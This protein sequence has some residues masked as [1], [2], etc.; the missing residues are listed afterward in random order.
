[1]LDLIYLCFARLSLE[2]LLRLLKR[3]LF[4]GSLRSQAKG[5]RFLPQVRSNS[6]NSSWSYSC[7]IWIWYFDRPS[8]AKVSLYHRVNANKSLSIYGSLLVPMGLTCP[9]SDKG[10]QIE[11]LGVRE[12]ELKSS[13]KAKSNHKV[14]FIK[15]ALVSSI[16]WNGTYLSSYAYT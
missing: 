7:S 12:K 5:I 3:N 13:C 6:T 10:D 16:L 2:P 1:M 4:I 11:F 14:K 8:A 9:T 15:R